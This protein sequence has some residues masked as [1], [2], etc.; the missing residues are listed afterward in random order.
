MNAAS[1]YS[2]SNLYETQ[3]NLALAPRGDHGLTLIEGGR[4]HAIEEPLQVD[5]SFNAA[6]VFHMKAMALITF[7]A[8]V[9]VL[10]WASIASDALLSAHIAE[11]DDVPTTSVVVK[12]GDCLLGIAEMHPVSGHTPE[13]VVAWIKEANGLDNA[14]ILVGQRL[15][16]PSVEA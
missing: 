3:G 9:T 11:L 8:L 1:N 10:V 13:E 14:T 4:S 7:L 6:L 2:T 12:G 5:Y 15:V 16:V